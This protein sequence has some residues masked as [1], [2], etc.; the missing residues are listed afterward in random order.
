MGWENIAH[1][2]GVDGKR[3]WRQRNTR[4][5]ERDVDHKLRG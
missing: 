2:H 4:D 1:P 3:R 5:P